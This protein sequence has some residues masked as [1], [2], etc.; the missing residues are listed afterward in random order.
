MYTGICV[1]FLAFSTWPPRPHG[2]RRVTLEFKR[3]LS[4]SVFDFGRILRHQVF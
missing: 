4:P 2:L 1:G 3:C